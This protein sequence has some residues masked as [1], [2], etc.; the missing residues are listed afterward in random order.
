MNW[1]IYA[2][3]TCLIIG[4]IVLL[5]V[6]RSAGKANSFLAAN[7]DENDLT[8]LAPGSVSPLV[9]SIAEPPEQPNCFRSEPKISTEAIR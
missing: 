1:T 5:A 2:G 9:D 3:S 4:V 8:N 6:L 7:Q